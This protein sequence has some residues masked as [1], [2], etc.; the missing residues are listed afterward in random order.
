MLAG[1]EQ[2]KRLCITPRYAISTFT[3]QS[4]ACPLDASL[5]H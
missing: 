3:A 5:S 2:M 4:W 1:Y